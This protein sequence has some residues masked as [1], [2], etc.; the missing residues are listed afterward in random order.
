MSVARTRRPVA[1]VLR[2]SPELALARAQKRFL[3][4]PAGGCPKCHSSYVKHEPAFVHCRH[5]GTLARIAGAPLDVQELFELR[6]GL[7]SA[8]S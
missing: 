4:A 2:L 7:R 6:S 5:C 1:R 8:A 3:T